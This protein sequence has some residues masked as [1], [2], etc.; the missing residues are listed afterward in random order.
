MQQVKY[1]YGSRLSD[2]T[3][4]KKH[5]FNIM[6]ALDTISKYAADRLRAKVQWKATAREIIDGNIPETVALL[7]QITELWIEIKLLDN[8]LL[9]ESLSAAHSPEKFR[10]LSPTIK[11]PSRL[12]IYQC[13]DKDCIRKLLQWCA[14]V[15]VIH[16]IKVV[17]FTESFRDC[18]VLCIL[19]DQLHP[20]MI[21]VK[22]II[23]VAPAESRDEQDFAKELGIVRSNIKLFEGACQRLGALPNI[24]ISAMAA[25]A[26]PFISILKEESFGR[27]MTLMTA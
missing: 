26:P 20:G 25:L 21:E 4:H 22:D 10:E 7:W 1:N 12:V 23:R 16:R 11:S 17:D 19:L 5:S 9:D 3:R 6:I 8:S 15:C 13:T 2:A 14:T 18:A 27:L 24:S